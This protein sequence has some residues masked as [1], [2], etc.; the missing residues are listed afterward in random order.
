MNLDLIRRVI[1]AKMFWQFG[2]NLGYFIEILVEKRNYPLSNRY[3]VL[4]GNDL[5]TSGLTRLP[6]L[7]RDDLLCERLK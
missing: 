7:S 2:A 1:A 4:I 5:K 3:T 6:D